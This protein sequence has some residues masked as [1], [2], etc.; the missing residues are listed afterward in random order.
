MKPTLYALNDFPVEADL[1]DIDPT[2]G[3]EVPI[4]SATM[5]LA[6]SPTD[7]APADPSLTTAATNTT[8]NTWLGVFDETILLPAVLTPL[9]AN[10]G[11]VIIEGGGVRLALPFNYSAT[12]PAISP[13]QELKAALRVRNDAEDDYIVGL[14][15]AAI[16]EIA[17]Q[18]GHW[19][20]LPKTV[21]ETVDG[22]GNT[23]WLLSDPI[24]ITSVESY[25][26]GLWNPVTAYENNGR[27]ITLTQDVVVWPTQRRVVYTTGAAYEDIPADIRQRIFLLVALWFEQR[28]P[29]VAMIGAQ[30]AVIGAVGGI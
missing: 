28:L 17:T 15:E 5:F 27:R 12:R 16:A 9:F 21:T 20:G 26:G 29:D 11:Y 7:I 24:T 25:E 13:L 14:Y 4:P 18:T 2:T 8:G 6:T 23:I 30:Q 1:V 3:L 10:G 22:Y 19:Y